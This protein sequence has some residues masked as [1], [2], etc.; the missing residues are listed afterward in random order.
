MK[1]RYIFVGLLAILYLS[2]FTIGGS[3]TYSWFTSETEAKGS[4]VNA[5]T[6]DLLTITPKVISYDKNCRV[7]LQIAVTNKSDINIPIKL[8]HY[9]KKLLPKKTMTAK[10]NKKVPC[11]A[12]KT[13]YH[14]TGLNNYIDK[15]II[16]QLNKR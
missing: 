4:V 8:G 1:K 6:K 3:R 10:F 5:T 15:D 12:A 7:K 11:G 13:V 2:A 9:Q 14:L 16:I